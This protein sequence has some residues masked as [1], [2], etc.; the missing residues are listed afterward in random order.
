M[1]RKYPNDNRCYDDLSKD[2]D[3]RKRGG[4]RSDNQNVHHDQKKQK[5]REHPHEPAE[6]RDVLGLLIDH[7]AARMGLTIAGVFKT[8]TEAAASLPDM[9]IDTEFI[10]LHVGK[11][12]IS[13]SIPLPGTDEAKDGKRAEEKL[14]HSAKRAAHRYG[15]KGVGYQEDEEEE[16]L[17]DGD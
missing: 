7:G 17:Y 3:N 4:E 5:D 11:D 9:D 2:R 12:S 10:Q 13:V 1:S 15:F 8:L 6:F 16:R 14:P